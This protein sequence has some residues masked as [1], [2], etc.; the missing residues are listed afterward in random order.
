MATSPI[1][2][3]SFEEYLALEEKAQFK[4][5][6]YQGQ[7]LAMSGSTLSHE[8]I[9]MNVR[10]HLRLGLLGKDCEV[11]GD[12]LLFRTGLDGLAAYPDAVVFCGQMKFEDHR[13]LVALNPKVVIEVLSPSTETYDRTT[14]AREYWK[15]PS[16]A[17]YFLIRQD[18][19]FV[20][21]Q[22][23]Q[24]DGNITIN[25]IEGRESDCPFASLGLSI[26]MADIYER[27]NF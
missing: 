20:E 22:S 4:N 21:I 24:A 6:F 16:V 23:R 17:Q 15:C 13:S 12:G 3:I 11:L 7:I 25:W 26:A 27:V 10:T 9:A 5:E 1:P 19:P 18:Q 8:R 2:L 14:K